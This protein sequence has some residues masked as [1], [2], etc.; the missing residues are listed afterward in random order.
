MRRLANA[1][2]FL[3]FVALAAIAAFGLFIDT[4][5]PQ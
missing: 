4:R 5:G 2:F 3:L 1:L